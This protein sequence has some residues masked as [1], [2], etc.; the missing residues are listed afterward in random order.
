MEN[1]QAALTNHKEKQIKKAEITCARNVQ[2]VRDL[3]KKLELSTD[4]LYDL[5][6]AKRSARG[7]R[8]TPDS[9]YGG[10]RLKKGSKVAPKYRL[11]KDGNTYLWVGRG[12]ML[13]VFKEFI[14]KGGSLDK[15]LI[16]K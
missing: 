4:D 9:P 14:E 2:K 7:Q 3:A 12:R 11:T 10:K 16:K 15:C 8:K 5:V 6:P 13:L 1:L